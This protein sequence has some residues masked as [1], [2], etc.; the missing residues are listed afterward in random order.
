M[1]IQLLHIEYG[2]ITPYFWFHL[3]QLRLRRNQ[4]IDQYQSSVFV[5][6]I[7][8][9][10]K[11]MRIA[12]AA[13]IRNISFGSTRKNALCYLIVHFSIIVAQ[14]EIEFAVGKHL[15]YCR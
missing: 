2:A 6:R 14:G 9:N 7:R 8:R 12:D 5:R 4:K 11:I 1:R 10:T 15:V 3:L 13:N